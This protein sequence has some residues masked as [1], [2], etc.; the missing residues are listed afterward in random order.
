MTQ[1]WSQLTLSNWES[2]TLDDK[3][4]ISVTVGDTT[5]ADFAGVTEF[6]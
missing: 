4:A 2:L 5:D 1:D 6:K 3:L